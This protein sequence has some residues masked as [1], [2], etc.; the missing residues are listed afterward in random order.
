MITFAER[1]K[2]LRNERSLSQDA[3]GKEMGISR[4]AIYT[5]E[6]GKA[7]PTVEGLLALADYFDVT[8]DY[9]LGRTDTPR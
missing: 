4:Y 9:L 8:T 1:L 2:Q 5:Y 3:L 6:S 7:F